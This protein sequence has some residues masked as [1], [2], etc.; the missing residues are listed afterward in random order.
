[1]GSAQ[2]QKDWMNPDFDDSA[3]PNA[4]EIG[5]NKKPGTD[6][7]GQ[8]PG[9][10]SKAFWIFSS[11]A[12]KKTSQ[13]AWCRV[14]TDHAWHSYS[15]E[16]HAATRWSCQSMRNRQSAAVLPL[17]EKQLLMDPLVQGK[18]KT[19]TQ[20]DKLLQDIEAYKYVGE[21]EEERV[22]AMKL[23][24]AEVFNPDKPSM[25][26][27][28]AMIK[29]TV[30]RLW[31][32]DTAEKPVK[33]CRITKD[34]KA[35]EGQLTWNDW[36][37]KPKGEANLQ[38]TLDNICVTGD[39]KKKGEF[40]SFDIT[41]WVREW[42]SDTWTNT[43]FALVYQ[44]GDK[45]KVSFKTVLVQRKDANVRPHLSISCHGD[46]IESKH[47]FKEMSVD[48]RLKSN[49]EVAA[50]RAAGVNDMGV[51]YDPTEGLTG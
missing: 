43:G 23:Q 22:I 14:H 19:E 33:L 34:W 40:A 7:W 35:K 27:E 13:E 32:N 3:W 18:G 28:G 2:E 6:P 51:M 1:M 49:A 31:T 10:A 48:F 15:T 9:I 39:A 44:P 47:V 50:K 8:M 21:I 5:N 24:L 30:L 17:S 36:I 12:W 46:K 11:H 25:I 26:K 16:H 20:H 29:K 42:L 38:G 4:A 45:D 41:E 37:G